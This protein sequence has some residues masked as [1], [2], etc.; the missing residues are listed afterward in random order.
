MIL[1]AHELA[2]ACGVDPYRSRVN[3]WLEH[4]GRLPHEE[5]TDARRAEA[6]AWG[7][8]LQ[9]VIADTLEREHG[10]VT[11][12]APADPYEKAHGAV[13]LQGHLDGFADIGGERGVLEI[14]T[15]SEW[16]TAYWGD[17]TAPVH[18]VT[19]LQTYLHL[20]G[21][22]RGLLACLVGGQRLELRRIDYDEELL[23]L[24]L[25][26]AEEFAQ[27]VASDTAP[28]PD[29]SEAT[30]QALARM[31]GGDPDGIVHLTAE[32][33]ATVAELRKVKEAR[34]AAETQEEEL[35]QRL[36]LRLG[37][38]TV[39]IHDGAPLVRWS[40][41][42]AKRLNQGKVKE[43]HPEVYAACVDETTYR[44]FTA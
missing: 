30:T 5:E 36:K 14:K 22:R 39:G 20:T 43:S 15:C 33:A 12:P 8:T 34:K 42:Q 23:M 28:A 7:V 41:V 40:V 37:D 31:Y 17:D 35:V 24:M 38:A 1:R 29:G 13:T 27:L 26:G 3:L 4:T 2:V 19:Q 21:L 18:Y 44:R 9:P 10:I 11:M 25:A 32:D 6:M 16:M